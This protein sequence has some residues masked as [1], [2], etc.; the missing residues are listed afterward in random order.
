MSV[1][2]CER[3]K[4]MEAPSTSCSSSALE[5]REA[6]TTPAKSPRRPASLLTITSRSAF[7]RAE[8]SSTVLSGTP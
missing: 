4:A 7:R 6:S 5:S 3:S 1:S 8:A 2:T